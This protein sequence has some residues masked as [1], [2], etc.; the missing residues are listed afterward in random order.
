MIDGWT[1]ANL[2]DVLTVKHGYAFKGE[3]FSTSGKYILL[4][5]GNFYES[6]GFKATA[7]KEKYYLADFPKSYICNKGDLVVAMTEQAEG[8]LGSTAL[9]PVDGVYLH[10]QRIGLIQQKDA[11]KTDKVFLYY[12]FNTNF[13]RKQIKGSSSGTKVKHTSPERIYEVK[14]NLPDFPTQQRVGKTLSAIDQKIDLNNEM[15]SK[16]E[17]LTKSLYDFWFVQY[18]FPDKNGKPYKSTGNKMVFN[19][20]LKRE[21][22]MG[23]DVLELSDVISR[24]GTGLNPRNHFKLGEGNN[25]YVTITNIKNGRVI[26]D[27]KCDR[28][29]DETLS[30][31]NRRSDLQPGDVL[32]TSIEPV[33]V[34]YLIQEKPKN[35]NINE[36]VFTVRANKEKVSPEYLYM[37]LSSQEMKVFTKN[38]SAGSIHK[39][40]RHTILKTFKF[41]YAGPE[42]VDM[43]SKTIEPMLRQINEID[44]ENRRLVELRDWLLPLLMNGQAY[45]R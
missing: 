43:F 44:E 38:A 36:S 6:G 14:V 7:G 5:P 31:I 32:F 23:W 1:E 3:N 26:L 11:S 28:I 33:G 42:L 12:L 30:I 22:P 16:L 10:N 29:S 17:S 39:G 8:L 24:T 45:I 21:I 25:Y 41:P 19:E 18:D 4:T 35:W 34:T 40:I 9:V 27:D 37:L 13:V 20:K 15:I 2:G